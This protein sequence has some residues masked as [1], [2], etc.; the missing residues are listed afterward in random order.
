MVVCIGGLRVGLHSRL[1]G[2]GIMKK[3]RFAVLPG[4]ILTIFLAIGTMPVLTTAPTKASTQDSD[5]W[6]WEIQDSNSTAT[7]QDISALD[8]YNVW[9]VGGGG[10]ILHFD[11][12]FWSSQYS[13]TN[14]FLYG[15]SAVD[16]NNVWAAGVLVEQG[17][18]WCGIILHY[19]GESWRESWLGPP[20]GTGTGFYGVSASS[21]DDVWAVG[22]SN[23]WSVESDCTVVHWDGASW[24]PHE[25]GPT[26]TLRGVS[27][28][29]ENNVWAAGDSTIV[30][31][32]G[33][34]WSSVNPGCLLYSVSAHNTENVWAVG[35]Y[36]GSTILYWNGATWK[37]QTYGTEARF[38]DVSALDENNVWAVGEKGTILHYDGVSWMEQP[39][40]TETWLYGVSALDRKNVWAVGQSGTILRGSST[41]E[42]FYFAEGYTGDGFHEWLC[43]G[44]PEKDPAR[45]SITYLFADGGTRGGEITVPPNSRATVNV[46]SEAGEGE[47]VSIVVESDSPIVAER[48]MYFNCQGRWAGGHDT[49][50]A[51]APS[52][53]WYF[54][55]GYTG[56]G[57]EEWIC[58]LN[59]GDA[60][61]ELTF[62]FQT[63][64]EG[65][66]VVEGLE[67]LPRS[68]ASFKVNEL[69]SGR[70]Y[71]TSL[72]L[73]SDVPIVA[74]RPMYF[75]YTGRG[76]W[77]RKGGHCVMGETTL[78]KQYYFAEGTTCGGFEEWLCIQNPKPEEITVYATYQLSLGQGE[79]EPRAYTVP[80]ASRETI[81]VPEEVGMDKDVS[82]HLSSSSPFLAE[83]PT[84]F[85]YTYADLS[86][87][88]G[89]CVIG[90]ASP[91]QEWFLAEGYTGAGFNQWICLQNPGDADATVEVT[92]YTQER[93]ALSPRQVIVHAGS[94][95]TLMVN[96]HAGQ[97]LQLSTR[98]KVLSGPEIVV[99]RPMYFVY[100]GVWDGGH[101]VVGYAP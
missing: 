48:P 50:G 9:A 7:L 28:L 101:A 35:G 33:T 80:G 81:F 95:N 38:H 96:E 31:W 82:V 3:S 20:N 26:M 18:G 25:P 13:G 57:F 11:G 89:H 69:L 40:G 21:P 64:E 56:E 29:D 65:E 98:V 12:S 51:T 83:R 60:T 59:P 75:D 4:I 63:Q 84:Y 74:E 92:Y 22:T 68:R 52:R 99:E 2:G 39:S 36:V 43:I 19:D 14:A 66:K 17:L 94:R 1:L 45:A 23:V 77:H 90:T 27:A 54:A 32:N 76:N 30:H 42:T 91:A 55:E 49:V 16:E 10:T 37:K 46:N 78:H 53:D 79:P 24:S 5:G 85:R 44:N 6:S 61:A 47:D 100:N 88:G 8:E 70:S 97:N 71:Q 67:V 73:A 93:G 34:S 62:Y 72:K 15:V 87:H 86:T 58:A 41:R